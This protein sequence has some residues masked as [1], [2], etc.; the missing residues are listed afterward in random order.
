MLWLLLLLLLLMRFMSLL[1]LCTLLLFVLMS[2]FCAVVHALVVTV[3][4]VVGV[5]I[6]VP[7]G[8]APAA[9]NRP[10]ITPWNAVEGK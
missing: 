10:S 2:L 5:V 4:A 7:A 3:S 9:D 8:A 1:S 6:F